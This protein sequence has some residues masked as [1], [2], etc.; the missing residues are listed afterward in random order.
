MSPKEF[1]ALDRSKNSSPSK[2]SL[3]SNKFKLSFLNDS[4]IGGPEDGPPAGGEG[5]APPPGGG[6]GAPAPPSAPGAAP[7]VWVDPVCVL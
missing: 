4:G 2:S 5:G 3:S 7:A 1:D 6:G